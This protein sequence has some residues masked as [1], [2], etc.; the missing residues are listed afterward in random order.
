MT[1]MLMLWFIFKA[2]TALNSE[3]SEAWHMAGNESRTK[4][5]GLVSTKSAYLQGN[6]LTRIPAFKTMRN[7]LFA[8]L[9]FNKITS[10]AP[11]DFEGATKLSILILSGNVIVSVAASAFLNLKAMHVVPEDHMQNVTGDN[12][13]RPYSNNIGLGA[14]NG[15]L[16]IYVLQIISVAPIVYG[17]GV[18]DP[19]YMVLQQWRVSLP[20]RDNARCDCTQTN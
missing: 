14:C 13:K 9:G 5:D 8:H 19:P 17:T 10:I 15:C 4:F 20:R 11:G 2:L 16:H 7:L 6:L 18:R 3:G 1:S 12:D